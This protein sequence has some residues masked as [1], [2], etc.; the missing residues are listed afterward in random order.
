[1]AGEEREG[2]HGSSLRNG[3]KTSNPRMDNMTRTD[4]MPNIKS[5]VTR[6]MNF[7]LPSVTSDG[8]FYI[9][10][11]QICTCAT[12]VNIIPVCTSIRWDAVMIVI[13]RKLH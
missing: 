9:S 10:T 13:A 2:N 7:T 1:M 4:V 6:V 12:D 3:K 8:C 11:E 5:G